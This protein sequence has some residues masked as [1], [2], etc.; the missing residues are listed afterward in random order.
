MLGVS[1]DFVVDQFHF[2]APDF[3]K[4]DVDGHEKEI[5]LGMSGLLKMDSL[6]SI[7]VEFNSISDKEYFYTYFKEFKFEPD[8]LFNNFPNHSKKRRSSSNNTAENCIF[9]RV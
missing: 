2:P 1:L 8:S 6:K 3:I 7:L 9:K 4:I 5:I